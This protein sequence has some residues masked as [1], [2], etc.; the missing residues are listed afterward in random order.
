VAAKFE[1][2]GHIA[3][4]K[5]SIP[6]QKPHSTVKHGGGGLMIWACFGAT[7]ACSHCVDHELLCVLNQM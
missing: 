1:M 6:A 7:G 3:Q 4:Q 5:H 2:F